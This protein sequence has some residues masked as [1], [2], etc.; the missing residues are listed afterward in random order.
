MHLL[1]E[2]KYEKRISTNSENTVSYSGDDAFMDRLKERGTENPEITK[3]S[4]HSE[5]SLTTGSESSKGKFPLTIEYINSDRGDGKE[6]L[7]NGTKIFGTDSIGQRPVL[8]SITATEMSETTKQSLLR[9][10]ESSFNQ[11]DFPE[12]KLK[13]GDTFVKL[14]SLS[15][16]VVGSKVEILITT[17]FTLISL[18]KN[19]AI[20]DLSQVH[21]M[22]SQNS[23]FEITAAGAGSGKIEF[24][25]KNHYFLEYDTDV[26]MNM[27]IDFGEYLM[28]L[29]QKTKVERHTTITKR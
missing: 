22:E 27:A 8:D 28:N 4:S 3:R 5:T 16:P 14:D 15:V 7:P 24:D 13:R 2:M 19:I 17:T 10:I 9:S 21:T 1:P 11:I 29:D 20:F 12:K 6:V 23:K 25:V 18:H 26:D